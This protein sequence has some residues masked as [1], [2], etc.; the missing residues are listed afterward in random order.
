[1]T[2]FMSCES[3]DSDRPLGHICFRSTSS[4]IA[5][6]HRLNLDDVMPIPTIIALFQ[7]AILKFYASS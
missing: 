6:L 3:M 2:K 4:Y 7:H 1:M 5:M